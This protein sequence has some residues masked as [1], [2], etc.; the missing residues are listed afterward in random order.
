MYRPVTTGRRT[1]GW[2]CNL[3][4]GA[5]SKRDWLS[6]K[7]NTKKEECSGM[8]ETCSAGQRR[9]PATMNSLFVCVSL[10][11]RDAM[12]ALLSWFAARVCALVLDTAEALKLLRVSA[13]DFVTQFV[14][15]CV[16]KYCVWQWPETLYLKQL[17][18]WPKVLRHHMQSIFSCKGGNPNATVYKSFRWWLFALFIESPYF[19]SQIILTFYGQT[20]GK[21]SWNV[22][23]SD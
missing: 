17:W 14:C 22:P 15:L 5:L 11:V 9:D 23:F 18:I 1:K 4:L 21:K 13:K 16:F 8:I 12:G 19:I 7:E 10:C 20:T 2:S 3:I 6:W